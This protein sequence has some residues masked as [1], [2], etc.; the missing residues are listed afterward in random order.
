MTFVATYLNRVFRIHRMLS[1]LTVPGQP[2]YPALACLG[3][4]WLGLAWVGLACFGLAKPGQ[5]SA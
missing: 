2:S 4:L 5:A 1:G 3:L